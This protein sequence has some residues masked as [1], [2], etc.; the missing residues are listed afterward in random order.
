[1]ND[2]EELAREIAEEIH[3]T[4]VYHQDDVENAMEQIIA[5]HLAALV[6]ERDELKAK[7]EDAEAMVGAYKADAKIGREWNFNSSLEK[8]FPFTAKEIAELRAQLEKAKVALTYVLTEVRAWQGEGEFEEG[9]PVKD[10]CDV[11]KG[12]LPAELSAKDSTERK[13]EGSPA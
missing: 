1:M 9:N 4:Y 6:Q 5:R 8:W 3:E 13:G 12:A 10:L 7:L 11:V 2:A